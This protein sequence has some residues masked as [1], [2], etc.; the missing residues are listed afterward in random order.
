M[1]TVAVWASL[2]AGVAMAENAAPPARQPAPAAQ[3]QNA[4]AP[5]IRDLGSQ[6]YQIGNIVVDKRAGRFTIPGRI[7]RTEGPLEYLVTAPGGMKAYETLLEVG[8]TGTEFNLACILVGLDADQ[9]KRTEFQFDRRTAEGQLVDLTVTWQA[10]GKKKTAGVIELLLTDEQRAAMPAS[11]WV[12]TGSMMYGNAVQPV[13][14]VAGM[15]GTL[16]GFV[17]DPA[18]IIEH[19]AGLGIGTYGVI[20]GNPGLLPPVDTPIEL[21]VAVT[22]RLSAGAKLKGD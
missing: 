2:V 19:R 13:T 17:H 1:V 15:T 5:A 3:P 22:G 14:F 16:I 8:A 6:R 11:E 7:L 20:A 18:T 4:Q 10:D 21:T 12:Y 9:S